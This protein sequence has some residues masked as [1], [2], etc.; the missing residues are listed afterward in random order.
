M[1]NS[2][3]Q[4]EF[5]DPVNIGSSTEDFEYQKMTCFTTT[6]DT[7]TEK[8][9]N[10]S[11]GAIFNLQKTFTYGDVFFILLALILLAYFVAHGVFIYF[12]KK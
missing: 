10:A 7:L 4:C 2:E 5:S 8:F 1:L 3:I 11:T 6:T 9:E 12:W